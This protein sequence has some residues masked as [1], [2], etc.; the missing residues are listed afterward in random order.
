LDI[1]RARHYLDYDPEVSLWAALDEFCVWW[2][3]QD[4]H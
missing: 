1:S 4:I 2:K 3:A